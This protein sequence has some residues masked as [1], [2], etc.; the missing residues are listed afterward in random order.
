[1]L[2]YKSLLRADH[3]SRGVLLSVVCPMFVIAKPLK[4]GHDPKSGQ[5]AAAKKKYSIL[6]IKVSKIVVRRLACVLRNIIL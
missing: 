5:S 2:F 3:S 4:G 6:T 1:M